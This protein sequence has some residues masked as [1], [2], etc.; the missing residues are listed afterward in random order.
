MAEWTFAGRTYRFTS[1]EF[2]EKKRKYREKYGTTVY[3]PGFEDIIHYRRFTPMTAEENRLWKGRHYADIPKERREEIRH[4]K[5]RKKEKFLAMLASPSPNIANNVGTIMTA[6]DDAQDAVSTL[7]CIG[8]IV[9]K[10]GG[11]TVAKLL[12][13]GVGWVWLASDILNAVNPYS[14]ARRWWKADSSGREPKRLMDK[15]TK[16]NPSCKKGKR[17]TLRRIKKWAPNSANVCEAAQT[18]DQLFGVGLN[19]GPIVGFAQDLSFAG[20]RTQAG[21]FVDL[22]FTPRARAEWWSATQRCLMHNITLGLCSPLLSP[23]DMVD[24]ILSQQ[25]ALQA[26]YPHVVA[27]DTMSMVENTEDI[28][29]H[30]PEPTDTLTL[31]IMDE[32]LPPNDRR[33]GLPGIGGTAAPFTRIE[34]EVNRIAK[35]SYERWAKANKW[36]MECYVA[37]EAMSQCALNCMT[38]YD[39][40]GTVEEDYVVQSKVRHKIQNNGWMYPDY[41][42]EPQVNKFMAMANDWERTGYNPTSKEIQALAELHCEFQFV[43]AVSLSGW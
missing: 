26:I 25:F 10:L 42:S 36:D 30:A 37:S 24:M 14:R 6:L 18:A 41:I 43:P 23:K 34:K 9:A 21:E 19:L 3:V 35:E 39:K 31:E 28:L 17:R 29:Y 40:D 16:Y 7:A 32:I 8:T 5:A 1:A 11:K 15:M 27:N 12:A 4:E 13:P 22:K 2:A 20:W 38:M 33:I